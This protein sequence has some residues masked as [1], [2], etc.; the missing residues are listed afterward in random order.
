VVPGERVSVRGVVTRPRR[1]LPATDLAVW[2]RAVVVLGVVVLP[3]LNLA[4][5]IVLILV[6]T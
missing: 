3:V 4:A 6:L 5:V 1:Q 2:E